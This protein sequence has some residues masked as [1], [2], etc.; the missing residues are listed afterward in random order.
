MSGVWDLHNTDNTI[1]AGGT[2]N[3][4]G[5]DLTTAHCQALCLPAVTR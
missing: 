2:L 5:L 1:G 4:W 3:S